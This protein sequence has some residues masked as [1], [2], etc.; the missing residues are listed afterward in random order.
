MTRRDI[1]PIASLIAFFTAVVFAAMVLSAPAKADP[2]DRYTAVEAPVICQAL[3]D[4]PSLTTVTT[5]F[6]AIITDT[7]FSVEDTAKVVVT[8]VMVWCPGNKV[9]LDRFVDVYGG[10]EVGELHRA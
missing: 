4:N 10:P 8:S 5:L 3:T 2:T 9:V 1:L 6:R 7:G